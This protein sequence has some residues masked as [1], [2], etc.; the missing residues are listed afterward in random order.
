MSK[1]YRTWWRKGNITHAWL[2]D[3][4]IP[5]VSLDEFEN[6]KNMDELLEQLW[7]MKEDL[8]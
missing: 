8:A 6:L 1:D 4:Y 3:V 2:M 7:A 5:S